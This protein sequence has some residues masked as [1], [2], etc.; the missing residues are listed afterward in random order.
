MCSA[1]CKCSLVKFE[2]Y[3]IW[4]MK[5]ICPDYRRTEPR[6]ASSGARFS[7]SAWHRHIDDRS[8]RTVQCSVSTEQHSSSSGSC[9]TMSTDPRTEMT[10]VASITMPFPRGFVFTTEIQVLLAI[11]ESLLTHPNPAP[12]LDDRGRT[13]FLQARAKEEANRHGAPND[14]FVDIDDRFPCR[15]KQIPTFLHCE[16]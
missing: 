6:V 16:T 10:V 4:Q 14:L 9:C 8:C 15:V 13:L 5:Y 11:I 2:G 7:N 12:V 3:M 1:K